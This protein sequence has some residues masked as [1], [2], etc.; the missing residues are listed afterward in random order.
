M[1]APTSDIAT[2]PTRGGVG[3]VGRDQA[4]GLRVVRLRAGLASAIA[5]T[6][7]AQ[8]DQNGESLREGKPVLETP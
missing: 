4:A 8:F 3:G 6:G 2:P 5:G 7:L 1:V